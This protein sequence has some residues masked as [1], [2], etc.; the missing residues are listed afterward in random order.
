MA[1]KG[2]ADGLTKREFLHKLVAAGTVIF[3]AGGGYEKPE[4]QT[5]L[6]PQVARATGSYSHRPRPARREQ[7]TSQ[8]KKIS[9]LLRPFSS[10]FD[11]LFR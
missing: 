5:L 3:V 6:G 11:F 10:L 2:S 7:I 8:H 1:C 4:L 9:F